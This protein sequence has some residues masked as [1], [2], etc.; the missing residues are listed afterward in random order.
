MRR[1][2][3]YRDSLLVWAVFGLAA[4]LVGS[5][6][7]QVAPGAEAKPAAKAEPAAPPAERQVLVPTTNVLEILQRG[8]PVMYVLA[9]CSIVGLSF[10][11]ERLVTLRR[12]SVIPK[13]FVARFLQQV[14]EGDLDRERALAICQESRSPIATIF[15]AAV[16]KW[17][18]PGVEVEQA[19]IDAGERATYGLRRYLRVFTSLA[20]VG[21]LLGLLGTVIGMIHAFNAVAGE[22]AQGRPQSELLAQGISEALLN[23]AFGLVIA[24]PAQSLYLYFVSRVDRLVI[25]MDSLGQELVNLISAEDL[26]ARGDAQRPRRAQRAER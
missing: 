8:G 1:S 24:I 7:Q 5:A 15:T 19:I 11:L 3:R 26:Q 17:G 25:D 2:H 22:A 13:P 4:L 12:S 23:T 20:V 16:R 10:V 9:F 14:R 21:P 6:A 18:R